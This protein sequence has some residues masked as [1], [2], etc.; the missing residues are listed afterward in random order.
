MTYEFTL[1]AR[2]PGTP[3]KIFDAWLSSDGHTAMTGG[4]AHVTPHVGDA[5][6]AWD[7]YI[8]GRTIELDPGRRIVQTWRTRHFSP[9]DADSLIEVLLEPDGDATLLTLKHSNVP[10]GQT[11]YEESGWRQ[12]YFEPMQ[13][14]LEWLRLIGTM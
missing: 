3:Q 10:A 1:T 6:D 5:F 14:R 9:E 11:S 12:H 4:V 13:R 7:G 2:L 8:T